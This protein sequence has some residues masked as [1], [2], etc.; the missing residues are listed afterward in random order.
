M[1]GL[2]HIHGT[3][4]VHRDLKPDNIFIGSQG[5]VRIGD[6][7]LARPGDYETSMGVKGNPR[8]EIARSFTRSVGT[9]TY[10]APEVRSGSKGRYNEKADMYSL[11]ICLFEMT[12]PLETSME[13]AKL[14]A[15]LRKEEHTLPSAFEM[16]EKQGQGTIILSLVNHKASERPSSAELLHSGKVPLEADESK[17]RVLEWMEFSAALPYFLNLRIYMKRR[18]IVVTSPSPKK[19]PAR[20]LSPSYSNTDFNLR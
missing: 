14:L 18:K 16:P 17:V 4:I 3:S 9:S 6:F 2:A 5:D 12:F 1:E 20:E 8:A 11:G 10:V 19:S 15:E 7:G 13:R